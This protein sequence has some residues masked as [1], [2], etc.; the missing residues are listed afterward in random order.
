[1]RNKFVFILIFLFVFLI[2]TSFAFSDSEVLNYIQQALDEGP[3]TGSVVGNSI[4]ISGGSI[5][6]YDDLFFIWDFNSEYR[7]FILIDQDVLDS[8]I[9]ITSSTSGEGFRF[10]YNSA[11]E[12]SLPAVNNGDS[13]YLKS[14]IVGLASGTTRNNF[15]FSVS[16]VNFSYPWPG[17]W[18]NCS[19]SV[20]YSGYNY[21]MN[22]GQ[23]AQDNF[24]LN[25]DYIYISTMDIYDK[26]S[27]TVLLKANVG[28]KVNNKLP[29]LGSMNSIYTENS[30]NIDLNVYNNGTEFDHYIV[31]KRYFESTG[32]VDNSL[33]FSFNYTIDR[34]R[35]YN[36]TTDSWTLPLNL[37]YDFN[38]S[39]DFYYIVEL[40]CPDLEVSVV[41][42]AGPFK[43]K[44]SD[45][46]NPSAGDSYD[47]TPTISYYPLSASTQK[48]VTITSPVSNSIIYYKLGKSEPWQLYKDPIVVTQN[49]TIYAIIYGV[50][51]SSATAQLDI[52]NIKDM[53]AVNSRPSIGPE[54]KHTVNCSDGLYYVD[55]Y[56]EY[57]SKFSVDYSTD[58]VFWHDFTSIA[59][60]S[61]NYLN[62]LPNCWHIEWIMPLP[63]TLYFRYVDENGFY[64][65]TTSV[66]IPATET[67]IIPVSHPAGTLNPY[68]END[69]YIF[70]VNYNKDNSS[71]DISDLLGDNGKVDFNDVISSGLDMGWSIITHFG[72]FFVLIEGLFIFIP[73]DIM[74]I[75]V[76]L[77]IIKFIIALI[78]FLR[79]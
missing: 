42:T 75:V 37:F 66:Y 47:I 7:A 14:D 31:I 27:D 11:D 16:T 70:D 50:D 8:D 51:G 29:Y 20:S 77:L 4:S 39:E 68:D 48:S 79:G 38:F 9:R 22:F 69:N 76:S 33:N 18:N 78:G 17:S 59:T 12:V 67:G 3:S 6:D 15:N 26:Y 25:H 2:N 63:K 24:D 28:D 19:D 46:F 54:V 10:W 34:E 56:V 64:S 43:V 52:T 21:Y 44:F 53:T 72:D 71:F 1:M 32:E 57:S 36:E 5:E 45:E 60:H 30:D 74:I 73:K 58:G 23:H 55:L 13:T 40:R 35:F 65:P 49:C 61:T 62:I 41:D